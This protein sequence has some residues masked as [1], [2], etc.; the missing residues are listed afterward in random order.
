MLGERGEKLGTIKD[1]FFVEDDILEEVLD[2]V[3]KELFKEG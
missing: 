2:K 1:P 3:M